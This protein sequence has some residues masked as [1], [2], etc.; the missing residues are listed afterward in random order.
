MARPLRILV[1]G[2]WYHVAAREEGLR[3]A[4]VVRG[5]P[6]LKYVAAAQGVERFAARLETDEEARR[7]VSPLRRTMSTV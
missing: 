3:L 6:G 5:V 4:E 7:F 1:A 2:G